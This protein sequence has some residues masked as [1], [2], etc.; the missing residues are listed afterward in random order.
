MGNDLGILSSIG[1]TKEHVALARKQVKANRDA[2]E[3][4]L[5][6]GSVQRARSLEESFRGPLLTAHPP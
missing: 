6:K 5:G 3:P 2:E 4:E 1:A